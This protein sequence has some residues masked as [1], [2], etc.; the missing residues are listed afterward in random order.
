MVSKIK[1]CGLTSAAAVS[2]AVSSGVDYLGFVFYEPSPRHLDYDQAAALGSK[3][4]GPVKKVALTVDA[5]DARLEAI[6]KSLNPDLMQL[7]GS[8]TP[9]RIAR[10]RDKFGIQVIKAIKIAVPDDLAVI[11]E[12]ADIADMLLFDAKMQSNDRNALPGG[13]GVRF[14]WD[15]LA[16][17]K[18]DRPFMLS[19]GLDASNVGA[20]IAQLHPAILDVSSG[21]ESAPGKKD[22]ALIRAFAKAVAKANQQEQA[23]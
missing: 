21:V 8:E 10:V 18:L 3:L 19:G 14:D 12:F 11:D 13:N 22:P 7:H 6:L 5:E 17:I 16:S 15:I 20:A 1:I 23:A 4:S 2:A 9:E